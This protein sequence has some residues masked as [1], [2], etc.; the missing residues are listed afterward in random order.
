MPS[1]REGLLLRF[2]R[3]LDEP[4]IPGG[5]LTANE[6]NALDFLKLAVPEFLGYV[7]HAKNVLDFGCGRGLQARALAK[8]FPGT[9]VVGIDL[10]RPGLMEHWN[11]P[12]PP[13]LT[14]TTQPVDHMAFDLVYS[15]SSFEHFDDP[16]AILK[17]MG[18]SVRPGGLLV[19]A[20][21]EPWYSPHGSHMDGFCRLP[22]VNLLFPESTVLRVR[23]RYRSDNATRYS[24]VEGGLNRMTVA[25]FEKIMRESGFTIRS[26]RLIS[27]KRLPLVSHIPLLREL[28]T[29]SCS[30]VLEVPAAR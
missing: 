26:L 14:L 13:N 15:C 25:R 12:W 17:L 28:L 7:Q 29:A 11:K 6:D 24:E 3:R 20:F 30:C 10:P 16:V 22:W 19:V 2:C 27:V 4:E 8:Q 21:A 9:Q 1:F 23:S 5:T 18:K